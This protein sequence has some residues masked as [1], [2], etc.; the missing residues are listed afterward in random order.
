MQALTGAYNVRTQQGREIIL[1]ICYFLSR[2]IFSWREKKIHSR[3]E[4]NE[5]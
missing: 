2:N 1:S 5:K 4:K 3:K